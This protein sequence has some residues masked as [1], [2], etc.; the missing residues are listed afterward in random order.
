MD[1]KKNVIEN[2][3]SALHTIWLLAWPTILEQIMQSMVSYADTA[4]VG[5]LGKEATAA[6]SINQSTVFLLNGLMTAIS[7]GFM[8]IVARMV[9]AKQWVD[10]EKVVRQSV[11]ASIILGAVMTVILLSIS[12]KICV[13]LGAEA[14]VVGP[15]GRYMFIFCTS[16][17]FKMMMI[18]LG[19]VLRGAG[20]MRTPMRINVIVNVLNVA[21][22]FLLIFPTRS[23]N[24]GKTSFVVWGADM[25][26]EGA[27]I[28]TSV[29]VAFG[30]IMMLYAI[31]SAQ[32][33]ARITAK[34]DYR[35][36]A[37][38]M[39]KVWG[40]ACPAVLERIAL[41][42][43]QLIVTAMVAGFG[44]VAL[45]SHHITITA[46]SLSY[47][48]GF[49]F[50]AAATTLVGQSLGAKREDLA[51][52]FSRITTI[53]GVASMAVFGGVLFAA[54]KPIVG[55]FTPDTAVIELGA[56]LLRIIAVVQPMYALFI[57]LTGVMRGA[58]DTKMP[59]YITLVC[60]WGIRIVGGYIWINCF[61]G[62]IAGVWVIVSADLV[63]RG[64]A[65]LLRYIS[66]KWKY[67][68]KG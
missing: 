38:I 33:A 47:M 23:V 6:V 58:G 42:S 8:A 16:L 17:L 53:I 11:T 20:N 27:A 65:S 21:G 49:G 32:S 3:S 60:M 24:I 52:K 48:P 22:N 30:G 7:I 9:G 66:G 28:A 45:A 39:K 54:A 13:W 61:S 51:D 31:Y 55:F 18:I 5:T 34:G 43:G 46:E 2:G 36:N 41:S 4:M 68:Y 40:I 62:G 1:E 37:G 19:A 56:T 26:V 14:D 35:V 50:A 12:T 25:G 10:V 64:A 57:V 29:S 44:T 15:A 67:A 63:A 59:F